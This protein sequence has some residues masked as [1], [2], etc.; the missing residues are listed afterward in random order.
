MC[1]DAHN[2]T[3]TSGEVQVGLFLQPMRYLPSSLGCVGL[4]QRSRMLVRALQVS[5]QAEAL[6]FLS[7]LR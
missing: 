7:Q 1:L 2:V 5:G 6:Q 4:R 3:A